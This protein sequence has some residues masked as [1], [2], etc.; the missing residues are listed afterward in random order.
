MM[1]CILQR[2]EGI[3]LRTNPLLHIPFLARLIDAD[4]LEYSTGGMKFQTV[5]LNEVRNGRKTDY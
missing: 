2:K 4:F 1:V 3:D 5:E